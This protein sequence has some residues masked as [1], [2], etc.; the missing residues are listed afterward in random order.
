MCGVVTPSM[1]TRFVSCQIAC[2]ASQFSVRVSAM[3]V[4]CA[5]MCVRV[6]VYVGQER[7]TFRGLEAGYIQEHQMP[8]PC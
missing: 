2:T 7:I 4:M 3:C 6:Y 1:S 8:L 5:Y